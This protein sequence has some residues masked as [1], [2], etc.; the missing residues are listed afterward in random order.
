MPSK[1]I[2]YKGVYENKPKEIIISQPTTI[3]NLIDSNHY[4]L[5]LQSNT[6]L[7]LTNPT[8]SKYTFTINN[9]SNYQ[10]TWDTAIK[11]E[12]GF[13]P[14]TS[15]TNDIILIDYDG[16]DYYGCVLDDIRSTLLLDVYPGAAAAYSL[17]ALSA[18]NIDQP[19]VGVRR[20][21]DDAEQDFTAAEVADGTMTD[22]V[23]TD[24]VQYTSDFTSG[25]E[26]LGEENG[27][28]TDGE[29]IDG[30]SDAYKFTLSGGSQ[31]HQ[32]IK[33]GFNSNNLFSISFD[34]YI[35]STNSKVDGILV[36]FVGGT[37]SAETTL[38]SWT[39]ISVNSYNSSSGG[40][41]FF[42]ARDGGSVTIDA[43]GDVFYLKNIVIT[44]TTADGHVV[45]WYDQSG[46]GNHATQ[47]TAASQPKIVD[48][49]VLVEENGKPAVDFDGV[50]DSLTNNTSLLGGLDSFSFVSVAQWK[51]GVFNKLY[52]ES[53]GVSTSN[54]FEIRKDGANPRIDWLVG[55]RVQTTNS[56]LTIDN[57]H[58]VS[59]Y[60]DGANGGEAYID[61]N[62]D[63]TIPSS[64]ATINIENGVIGT[65]VDG[66]TWFNGGVQ[67]LIIYP[68]DQSANRT[69]I[70]QNI[71]EHYS[72]YP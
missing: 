56:F 25:N 64:T 17:R 15:N 7:T 28:G 42:R 66:G 67:E 59:V 27:V 5:N 50:N 16:T 4:T 48:A 68:S 35:P 46:N 39:T 72:I 69:A 53:D 10:I 57:Q 71:N 52:T 22:W 9:T 60:R 33:G 32:A 2:Y 26:D 65:D 44:Q 13:P 1:N 62:L 21:S 47:A 30:V 24:V 12:G 54:R 23:N 3:I 45:T 18:S 43:D 6:N 40:N 20:S 38:D 34:Y 14:T 70:E 29:T 63:A 36:G 61:N 8:T 58:L 41:L 11:W 19:V 49:G 51:G 37:T 31:V 55:V